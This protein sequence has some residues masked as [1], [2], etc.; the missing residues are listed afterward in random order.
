MT[1]FVSVAVHSNTLS[2]SPTRTCVL[3]ITEVAAVIGHRD[4][5]G[6]PVFPTAFKHLAALLRQSAMGRCSQ[7]EWLL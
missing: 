3:G 7:I 6:D 4:V 5:L 2:F 1:L